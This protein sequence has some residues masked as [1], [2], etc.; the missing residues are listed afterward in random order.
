MPMARKTV[1]K[2]EVVS[3]DSG[4]LSDDLLRGAAAIAKFLYG[5]AKHRQKVYRNAGQW[6]LFN[7]G[8][9]LCAR[10]SRLLAKIAELESG[11]RA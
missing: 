4:A 10:K 8:Q 9:I 1:V 7:D 3:D 2:K 6:P 11:V 5:H